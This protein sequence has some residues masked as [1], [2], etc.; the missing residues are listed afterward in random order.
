[1][2]LAIGFGLTALA[3]WWSRFV[4][5]DRVELFTKPAATVL[6]LGLV[7]AT[8]NSAP[9]VRFWFGLAMVLCLLGDVALLPT[10]DQF[11]VGLGAFL[12][13]RVF[14][15]WSDQDWD[16]TGVA[17]GRSARVGRRCWG[18]WLSNS[19]LGQASSAEDV[20]AGFGV[21]RRDWFDGGCAR[22]NRSSLGVRWCDC[23]CRE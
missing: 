2:V 16:R 8:S 6:T 5:N 14:H 17:D 10:V 4:S 1:M 7:L 12:G 3:N 20:D 15:H 13:A 11:L 21:S 18:G 23:L 22:R 19:G 9:G